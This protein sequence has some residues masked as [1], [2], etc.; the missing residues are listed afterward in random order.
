MINYRECLRQ[1]NCYK[2]C[3]TCIF[4]NTDTK[5]TGSSLI[6][7]GLLYNLTFPSRKAFIFHDHSSLISFLMIEMPSLSHAPFLLN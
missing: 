1:M 4:V 7:A 5:E 2:I 6:K 3:M